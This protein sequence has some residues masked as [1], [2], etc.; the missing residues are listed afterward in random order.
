MASIQRL[1][2]ASAEVAFLGGAEYHSVAMSER[3]ES[4]LREVCCH[5]Y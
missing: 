4:A 2:E 3:M 5:F 1:S